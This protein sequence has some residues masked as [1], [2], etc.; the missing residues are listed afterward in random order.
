MVK[1]KDKEKEKAEKLKALRRELEEKLEEQLPQQT[2][3]GQTKVDVQCAN[4]EELEDEARAKQIIEALLFAAGKPLTVPDIRK[5][6]KS[7]TPTQICTLIVDIQKEYEESNRSFEIVQVANGYEIVTKKEF[8]PWILKV[9]LQKKAKQV[10]QSALETLA[11]LAYKQPITRAEI[12]EIR[13]VD[14]SGVVSTLM[15]RN[16]I[17][18][19]GKKDVPG[20]PFLYGTTDKF[21]EHFGLPSIKDLPNIDEIRSLVDSSVKRDELIGKKN[22]VEA[23]EENAEQGEPQ[24]K[25]DEGAS[26]DAAESESTDE[27]SAQ[28]LEEEVAVE[29][30]AQE[31]IE[32]ASVENV[33]EPVDENGEEKSES[34]EEEKK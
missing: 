7:L 4:E 5:T 28:V 23:A 33:S 21:L 9:E 10:T 12:E 24:A 30:D 6:V 22:V 27:A 32:E 29:E 18:I 34:A 20:R 26:V 1:Q 15:E 13:G 11:I 14:A 3:E 2:A 16:L 31:Q 17:K 25:G 19:V 8:A